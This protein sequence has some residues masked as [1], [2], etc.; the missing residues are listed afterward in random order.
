[1]LKN[2]IERQ[3]FEQIISQNRKVFCLVHS[4]FSG[5]SYLSL[6]ILQDFHEKTNGV[7]IV[8]DN[9]GASFIYDWLQKQ[10]PKKQSWIHGY[11]EFFG[12]IVG[13]LDWFIARPYHE[14]NFEQCLQIREAYFPSSKANEWLG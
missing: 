4:H 12:V 3:D 13:K 1:M 7:F 14:L 8:I 6:R 5:V 9:E 2:I 10:S 11:G